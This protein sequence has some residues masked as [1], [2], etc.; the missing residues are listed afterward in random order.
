MNLNTIIAANLKRLRTDRK[1]SLGKLSEL[2]GVSKVMLGQIERGE[3]NPTIN[4][5]WKIAAGLKVP[6]TAL[7]DEPMETNI[8]IRKEDAKLQSAADGKYR[9][10]CYFT[11]HTNQNFELFS[12][13][14]DPHTVYESVPHG[15]KAQ[16]YILIDQ[17][18]L[19]LTIG[20]TQYVLNA[21]DSI[22]FDSMQKHVYFNQKDT[23]LRMTIINY[24]LI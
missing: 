14:V 8:C 5:I 19:T 16:E 9:L 15:E 11:N 17:G 1:L 24:Y 12:V 20:T 2:C 23:L 4:T 3:S 10:Y 7:I 6:Y 21:G 13:E 22:V 18:Q